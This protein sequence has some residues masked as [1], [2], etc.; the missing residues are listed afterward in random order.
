M[1]SAAP[2]LLLSLSHIHMMP[3]TATI[4][5]HRPQPCV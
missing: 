2:P 3:E 5:T 1:C 4:R